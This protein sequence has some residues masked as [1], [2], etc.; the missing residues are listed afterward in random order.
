VKSINI[1]LTG[2]GGQGIGLLSELLTRCCE[3]AGYPVRGC[4]THGLA[5]R[6]GTVVSHLRI[7]EGVFTP[8]VPEGEADIIVS[9]ERLEAL[10]AAQNM[11]KPGGAIVYY[12]AVYQP[13][14]VRSGKGEYPSNAQL[15]SLAE[16]RKGRIFR[17]FVADLPD[18]RMQN[19][20]LMAKIIASGLIPGITPEIANQTLADVVPQ[21]ALEANLALFERCLK[22]G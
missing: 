16:K 3:E 4:D 22:L 5:Q 10:R 20:A 17:V 19:I 14:D 21:R 1:Y 12:D 7:G 13:I 2:V 6:G 15:E 9:L 18:S 8:R 11:M